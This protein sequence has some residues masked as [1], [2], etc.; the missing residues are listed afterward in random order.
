MVLL[1]LLYLC[2]CN[3]GLLAAYPACGDESVTATKAD[4]YIAR[5]MEMRDADG[6]W[7]NLPEAVLGIQL[8]DPTSFSDKNQT[9]SKMMEHL[10]NN[11]DNISL[12]RL[13]LYAM[14]LKSL[15]RDVTDINGTDITEALTT[16]LDAEFN[17]VGL[18]LKSPLGGWFGFFLSL[19]ALCVTSES[20]PADFYMHRA[21]HVQNR[22]GSFGRDHSVGKCR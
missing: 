16:K 3:I 18:R 19:G 13:A 22:D 14:A 17:A 11:I 2:I 10:Q 4:R 1:A 9:E 7:L 12:G 6:G 15:C 5:L 8:S 21:L 20:A